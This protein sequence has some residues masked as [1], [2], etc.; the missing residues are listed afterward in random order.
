MTNP[1]RSAHEIAAELEQSMFRL[2]DQ[3][4]QPDVEWTED[5]P[6][7][8][9]T[10]HSAE[11]SDLAP[12][13]TVAEMRLDAFL[14]E[15]RPELGDM[16]H[17]QHHYAEI[18]QLDSG[19]EQQRADG[20][21]PPGD[22][23]PYM[24]GIHDLTDPVRPGVKTCCFTRADAYLFALDHFGT[25]TWYEDATDPIIVTI[26]RAEADIPLVSI[27]GQPVAVAD[28]V[29]HYLREH[30]AVCALVLARSMLQQWRTAHRS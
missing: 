13:I 11:A 29:R 14:R 5:G 15:H 6:Q 18:D 7:W 10:F 9:I 19:F 1:N 12:V 3:D 23:H 20:A 16:P 25:P 30:A 8:G 21:A 26:H 17:W 4:N 27:V 2:Y 28:H 24:V 22:R